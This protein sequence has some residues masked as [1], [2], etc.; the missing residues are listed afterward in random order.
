MPGWA[1]GPKRAV[2][3]RKLEDAVAGRRAIIAGTAQKLRW[4]GPAELQK[5]RTGE[6]PGSALRRIG[7]IRGREITPGVISLVTSHMTG[8]DILSA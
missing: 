7:S 6:R 8:H 5:D 4:R 3:R 1:V 2:S